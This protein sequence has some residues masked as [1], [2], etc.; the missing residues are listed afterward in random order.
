MDGGATWDTTGL[1]FTFPEIT[2][3][4]R[5]AINPK[6]SNTIYA[7]TSEG[8]FKSYNAGRTW[9]LSHGV[10][11]AM[12]I[13]INPVDTEFVYVSCGNLN[14]TTGAGIYFTFDA[15]DNWIQLSNGLPSTNFGR[16]P[17]TISR[18]NPAILYAGVSDG[19]SGV[20]MGAINVHLNNMDASNISYTARK[21]DNV[22]GIDQNPN[23]LFISGLT[24]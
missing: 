15:G 4:Q 20:A 8:T 6:N 21:G 19:S 18:T 9:F 3:I 10:L 7:A 1:T 12:D 14:S 22:A 11:M 24:L 5:I 16:T 17:L 23:H 2:A 13:V